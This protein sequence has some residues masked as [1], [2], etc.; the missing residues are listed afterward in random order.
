MFNLN[1]HLFNLLLYECQS[2][3]ICLVKLFFI[4]LNFFGSSLSCNSFS[5]CVLM[6][7][8][9]SHTLYLLAISLVPKRL[10][11]VVNGNHLLTLYIIALLNCNCKRIL[12]CFCYNYSLLKSLFY[13][14]F[15]DHKPRTYVGYE[16]HLFSF[17]H[18]CTATRTIT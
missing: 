13:V 3:T 17:I 11:C 1:H 8:I 2:M 15:S 5:L 10:S 12:M 14:V 18:F 6:Y 16:L 4:H 7:I 9:L